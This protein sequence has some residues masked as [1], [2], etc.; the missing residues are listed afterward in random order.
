MAERQKPRDGM[1][2]IGRIHNEQYNEPA[3][4]VKVLGPT[5]GQLI[6]IGALDS[7]KNLTDPGKLIAIWNSGTSAHNVAFG[8]DSSVAAPTGP[9]NGIAVPPG[10]YTV[11][12]AGPNLWVIADDAEV[13]GYIIVDDSY[14]K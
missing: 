7:A 2:D 6:P 4:A 8:S 10:V 5:L 1:R 11:L 13:F 3:G 14:L 12:A 9:A